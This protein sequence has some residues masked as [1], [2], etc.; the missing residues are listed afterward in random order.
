MDTQEPIAISST[1]SRHSLVTSR[2]EEK[3]WIPKRIARKCFSQ[4]A[5]QMK[6]R[7]GYLENVSSNK[8]S[9]KQASVPLMHAAT[10]N[11][12]QTISSQHVKLAQ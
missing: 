3:G 2:E 6:R 8:I 7:D 5:R 4:Q 9:S 10:N 11:L 12:P 1:R